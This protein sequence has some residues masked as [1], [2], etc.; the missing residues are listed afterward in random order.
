MFALVILFIGN[1]PQ[2]T[3]WVIF[4]PILFTIWILRS[5]TEVDE[6]GIHARYAFRGP[7]S[8]SW[9]HIRGIGFKGTRAF[10]STDKGEFSLPGVSFNDLPKLESASAGRIPDALSQGRRAAS[11]K[12]RIVRR[13]GHEVLV[14]KEE[15]QAMQAQKARPT[16]AEQ[17]KEAPQE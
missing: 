16:I 15:Y 9:E 17:P 4:F 7:Q 6:R 2:Y 10:V 1:Q 12:V 3:F 8:A 11:E 14:S 13:D 5:S